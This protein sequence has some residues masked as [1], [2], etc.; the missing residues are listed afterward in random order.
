MNQTA[1]AA[2]QAITFDLCTEVGNYTH[3]LEA[4][5]LGL[6]PGQWPERLEVA[7]TFGNGMPLV[8]IDAEWRTDSDGD[9]ELVAVNYLQAAG[10][11][12]LRVFN[13]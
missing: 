1:P 6:R 9:R 11:L 8:R 10:V 4:S 12:R 7:R 2:L 3:V 5:T 13:D